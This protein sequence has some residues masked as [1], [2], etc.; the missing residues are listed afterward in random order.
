MKAQK[1]FTLLEMLVVA[2][3]IVI[4]V[5]V[6]L[7]NFAA[8]IKSN[9]EMSEMGTLAAALALARDTAAK[10]GS[11]VMICASADGHDCA[12]GAWST[13]FTVEYVTPPPRTASVIRVFPGLADGSKLISSASDRIVFHPDGL[14]DLP[15]PTTFT[16]CDGRGV[17]QARALDLL[18]SGLYQTST[19][20]GQ[21]VNG[22]PLVCS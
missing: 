10:S 14:T 21:D 8:T 1:G 12:D 19:T 7:P 3:V 16:L 11:D 13:G 18:V 6:A 17:S 22:Q 15:G 9:R 5:T 4:L 20:L 2:A